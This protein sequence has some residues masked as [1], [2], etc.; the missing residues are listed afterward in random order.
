MGYGEE[1]CPLCYLEGKG[2]NYVGERNGLVCS[3]CL[4]DAVDDTIHHRI[5]WSL[6]DAVSGEIC[7]VCLEKRKLLFMLAVCDDHMCKSISDKK[8]EEKG[9]EEKD[10]FSMD[11][12]TRFFNYQQKKPYAS[13]WDHKDIDTIE[14][15]RQIYDVWRWNGCFEE[16]LESEGTEVTGV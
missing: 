3:R 7:V 8:E 14:K 15:A 6:K 16:F 9:D 2:N 1:E 10:D 13:G 11:L 5:C 4:E 12:M